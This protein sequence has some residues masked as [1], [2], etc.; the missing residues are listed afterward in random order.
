MATPVKVTRGPQ[1]GAPPSLEQVPIER[2]QVDPAYQ[3]A[4]DTSLSR[5]IIAGMVKEWKWP[6]CQP[7]VVSRRADGALYVLD[8]Q[9]RLEGA[10][11]RGDLPYLPCVI[12]GSLGESDEARAFVDLNTQRQ[13]LSQTDIFNGLLAA[14]DAG[15]KRLVELLEETGWRILRSTNTQKM[16]PGDLTC[17]PMLVR[18]LG[19]SGESTVR[20]ALQALRTAYPAQPVTNVA[21][22][23]KAL[24][25]L[26]KNYPGHEPQQVAQVLALR[27]PIAW[28]KA[29]SDLCAR[30]ATWTRIRALA[31]VF[32]DAADQLRG[33]GKPACVSRPSCCAKARARSGQ[34]RRCRQG[35]VRSMRATR[36]ARSGR[37]LPRQVLRDAQG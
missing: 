27:S 2:L 7:L 33:G 24:V 6:L 18:E 4:T 21:N 5:R 36:F 13:R 31:R 35:L 3:R 26:F 37:R 11:Q 1:T 12:L 28:A 9:H 14:G 8:G 17:A 10:R 29:A 34:V 23:L 20:S 32:H 15:A 16:K 30:D 19:W 25:Q 22:M